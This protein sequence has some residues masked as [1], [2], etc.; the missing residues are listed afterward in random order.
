MIAMQALALH[1]PPFL[2]A[3]ADKLPLKRTTVLRH[4]KQNGLRF[5]KKLIADRKRQ[6]L[7][8]PDSKEDSRDMLSVLGE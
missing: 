5:S 3:Q 6:N 8:D 4:A 1:L 7:A 2:L